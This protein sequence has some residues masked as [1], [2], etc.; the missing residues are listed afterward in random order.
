MKM[1]DLDDLTMLDEGLQLRAEANDQ[2]KKVAHRVD[3]CIKN[4]QRAIETSRALL[5]V[6]GAS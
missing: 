6:S 5:D 3:V 4:T 1:F 2:C